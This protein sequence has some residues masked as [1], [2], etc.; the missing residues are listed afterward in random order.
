R[1][2]RPAPRRDERSEGRP[3]R[4][5]HEQ[6]PF[7]RRDDRAE[8]RPQRENREQRPFPRRDDRDA[9]RPQREDRASAPRK[10]PHAPRQDAH[11][12]P[13]PRRDDQILRWDRK[14]AE[15]EQARQDQRPRRKGHRP[16]KGRR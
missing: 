2:D 5:N 12:R 14:T 1:G 6:R 9:G 16:P 10:P 7:P 4:D 3:Q 11:G 15:E 13:I 8:G